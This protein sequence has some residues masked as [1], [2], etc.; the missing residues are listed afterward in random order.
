M[1]KRTGPN[2]PEGKA[3]S[4]QNA[5]THGMTSTLLLI[6]DESQ[7]DLDAH[8]EQW[9]LQYPTTNQIAER[10]VT[11][12]ALSEWH[13][14]RLERQYNNVSSQLL[15]IPITEWDDANH[16]LYQNIQRYLTTAQRTHHRDRLNVQQYRAEIRREE[17]HNTRL[18]S[19][20][21]CDPNDYPSRAKI[22]PLIN[23]YW[24]LIEGPVRQDITLD[25]DENGKPGVNIVPPTG[26]LLGNTDKAYENTEFVRCIELKAQPVAPGYEWV[27]EHLG[28]EPPG[29]VLKIRL[30]AKSLRIAAERENGGPI[31]FWPDL[32][33]ID[34][35]ILESKV[36][37]PPCQPRESK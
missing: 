22:E 6:N 10:Q 14:L 11:R 37:G 36:K 33:A 30:T 18:E 15:A 28:N 17:L 3:V 4:S 5:R 31:R 12:A 13:L 29:A 21:P 26:H 19:S 9:R 27:L 1:E 34:K 20:K 8:L 32:D 35:P 7:A 25:I 16:K 24:P 23:G 2:T